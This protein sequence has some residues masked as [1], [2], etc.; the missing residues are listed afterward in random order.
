MSGEA[1]L[2]RQDGDEL[3][4][5]FA[6]KQDSLAAAFQFFNE[7]SAQLTR[8][9]HMLESKVAE[10]TGEL[11]R[12]SAEKVQEQTSREQ[13]ATQMQ[14]LL[15]VL[16][17]GV[18]VLDNRGYIVEC[19]PAARILLEVALEGRL[20]REVIAEC[21]APKNDDGLEVSTRAGRRLSVATSSL[22][23]HRSPAQTGLGGQIILLTDLTETRELQQRVSR[24]ERLSAMGKMVSALAHQVRTPLSA[25]MLYAEHLTQGELDHT[26][27]AEFSHKLYG[28][29]QHM[30]RQ[31]RDMLLFVKSELPLNDIVGAGDLLA[32]LQAAAEVPLATSKSRCEWRLKTPVA[33]KCHR[34]AL[35]SALMNLVTN[36]IQAQGE[37]ANLEVIFDCGRAV[38]GEDISTLTI[39]ISDDGPGMSTALLAQAKDLFV[40]TKAQG[41]GLGLAVVQSVARAHGGQFELFSE[42]GEGVTALLQIP[43]YEQKYA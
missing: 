19:N 37:G 41:T 24:S 18:I 33:I 3:L 27:R 9:Y 25:A 20:W 35:I 4:D 8:S 30:E 36:A 38:S 39:E 40:T 7:T 12:V 34:E 5:S 17:A 15:E 2:K 6:D 14:T 23:A 43:V 29:L 21:F 10:L 31:V 22:D 16:P 32:G 13:L 26:K 28:R 42:P 1:L 11:D